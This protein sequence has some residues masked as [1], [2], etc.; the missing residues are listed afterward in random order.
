MRCRRWGVLLLGLLAACGDLPT[1]ATT[2]TEGALAPGVL[3][4]VPFQNRLDVANGIFQVKL[5][6]GTGET[7]DIVAVQLVWAGLT[8][9]VSPRANPL[10]AGDRLDYPVPLAPATCAGDGT[11]AAMPDLGAALVKVSLRDGRTLDV[12]VYD[13]HHVA[14]QLYLD[15][16][17]RQRI[18]AAV[19][20]E[21]ADL[22]EAVLD[23]RPVTEGVLRLTRRAAAGAVT[24]LF[25]SN[26]VTFTFDAPEANGGPVAVLPKGEASV[27]VPVRFLEGRCD[28]HA[29]S[30]TSQ[31]FQ[32]NVRLDLGDGL[33]RDYALVP[34]AAEQ[35]AMRHRLER[36][37]AIL[38]DT[39]FVGQS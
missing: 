15:D 21:W 4:A 31:P 23:G 33:A 28:A 13:V 3:A 29:M 26:T 19:D 17:E 10:V 30:E 5:Y 38:G 20:V 24:V 14:A 37:C 11:A 1:T 39:G 35:P 25:V 36:A 27:G 7:Y 6:N 34:G 2:A 32:F 9:P 12:P 18:E 16:C 22:H 8:T